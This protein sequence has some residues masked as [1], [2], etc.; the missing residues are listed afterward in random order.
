MRRARVVKKRTLVKTRIYLVEKGVAWRG[1]PA[2]GRAGGAQNYALITEGI[3]LA[4][5]GVAVFCSRAERGA[6]NQ[7]GGGWG[8][9]KC[10][11]S[12]GEACVRG[13]GGEGVRKFCVWADAVV[14]A[15]AE[16]GIVILW[17]ASSCLLD[18]RPVQKPRCGSFC[19]Y[20]SDSAR[21]P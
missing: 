7:W 9:M 16:R 14:K 6:A 21:Q 17:V 8:V 2:R 5:V 19:V 15:A 10:C 11:W 3:V 20:P 4:I 1:G 13:K 18:A 12:L